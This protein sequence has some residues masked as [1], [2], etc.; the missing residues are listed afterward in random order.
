MEIVCTAMVWGWAEPR[1]IAIHN[2]NLETVQP[3]LLTQEWVQPTYTNIQ[4][5]VCLAVL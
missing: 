3:S 4:Y 2:C 5:L 1:L